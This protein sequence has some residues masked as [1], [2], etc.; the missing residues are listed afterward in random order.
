MALIKQGRV[1][2]DPWTKVSGDAT[3]PAAGAILVPYA[4]WEQQRESLLTRN[5]PIGIALA[6]D[7]SPALIEADL[8]RFELIALEF[9]TFKDG[10]AYSQARLLRERYGFTGELR[11]TGDVLR[12]QFL[13]L[14]RCGFDAFEVTATRQ[15]RGLGGGP[16]GNFRHLSA[17]NRRPDTRQRLAAVPAGRRLARSGAHRRQS[18]R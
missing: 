16:I 5:G 14:H 10:R 17:G 1:V 6:G 12:D 4:L 8:A 13:F 2:D 15:R 7:Q 3:P 11:A 18:H 9:P